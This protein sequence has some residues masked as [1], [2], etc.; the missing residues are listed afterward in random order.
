LGQ[1]YDLDPTADYVARNAVLNAQHPGRKI[2]VQRDDLS[3][4]IPIFPGTGTFYQMISDFQPNVAGQM[5]WWCYGDTLYK[6]N[7]G[8]PIDPALALNPI[9][10]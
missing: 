10:G 3:T 7:N 9:G 1:G 2:D 6:V 4:F 8:V 5:T